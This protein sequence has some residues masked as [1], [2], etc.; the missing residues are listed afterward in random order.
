MTD[1][2]RINGP[3]EGTTPPVFASA[4][5]TKPTPTRAPDSLRK[6]CICSWSCPPPIN[7]KQQLTSSSFKNLP[8]PTCNRLRLSRAPLPRPLP[9]LL[10]PQDHCLRLWP[11]SAAFLC[12][13]L[14]PRAPHRRA[15]IC[16]LLHTTQTPRLR[17]RRRRARLI[18]PTSERTRQ[19]HQDRCIPQEWHRRLYYGPRL[20]R[21]TRWR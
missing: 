12:C 14:P 20:R 8:Y 9:E 4:V 1:R 19:E 6:I 16:A 5:V 2:R 13:F 15:Q 21:W 3:S 11:S 18:G 7:Q 17:P 10:D